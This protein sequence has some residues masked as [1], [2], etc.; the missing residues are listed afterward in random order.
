VQLSGTDK[1]ISLKQTDFYRAPGQNL[2]IIYILDYK[3]KVNDILSLSASGSYAIGTQLNSVG[4]LANNATALS[5]SDSAKG[6]L[7][8]QYE[9][10]VNLQSKL[11]L[12]S[13]RL[14][15]GGAYDNC[16]NRN[17]VTTHSFWRE[18]SYTVLYDSYKSEGNIYSAYG[19]DEWKIF[20]PLTAF[21][22]VR[23]DDWSRK[24]GTVYDTSLSEYVH[25][26]ET[27]A[28]VVSPKISLVYRPSDSISIRSSVGTAFN[29]PT[30]A[31]LYSYSSSSTGQTISNPNL[32]PEKDVSWELG[33]EYT[34][35]T[36][37]T[38]SGTYFENY[39]Q[40]LIYTNVTFGLNNYTTTQ[41][42]NAG[43]AIVKGAEAEIKHPVFSFLDAVANYTYV[44]DTIVENNADLTSVGK[45]IPGIAQHSANF[46]LNFKWDNCTFDF[47]ETYQSKIYRTS[48]NSDTVNG[49]Q[50]SYDPF[51]TSY[52]KI[53]YS[54]GTAKISV[55]VENIGG[56][57]YYTIY[58]T[59]GRTY[60]IGLKYNWQ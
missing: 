14:I 5:G 1:I 43:K 13:H 46:Q 2:M 58:Q 37:T 27:K 28:D 39:L 31:E 41:Y 51:A 9:K 40:D 29:P 6:G 26:P 25:Y 11:N 44:Y 45:F 50:G 57:K 24:N 8:D 10:T 4:T 30:S 55:G 16:L 12:G 53:A 49:V 7:G 36:K 18:L 32:V 38:I 33:G 3:G 60:N 34:L 21:L 23:Y 54:F 19:Q 52:L 56:V 59:P 20:D 22:G 15:F 47:T 48:N 42:V 17:A 35:P